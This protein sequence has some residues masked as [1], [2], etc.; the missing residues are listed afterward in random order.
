MLSHLKA[1]L[2]LYFSLE[3][4]P[5]GYAKHY[6]NVAINMTSS[7]NCQTWSLNLGPLALLLWHASQP[8]LLEFL[9]QVSALPAALS[10]ACPPDEDQRSRDKAFFLFFRAEYSECLSNLVNMINQIVQ[11]IRNSNCMQKI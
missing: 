11:K 3:T 5:H 2:K 8:V 10:P 9:N 1:Q 7:C 6:K 4:V